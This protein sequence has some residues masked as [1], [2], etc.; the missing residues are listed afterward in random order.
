MSTM[1]VLSLLLLAISVCTGREHHHSLGALKPHSMSKTMKEPTHLEL[2]TQGSG[3]E[4]SGD[5][6]C[7]V[8]L[9]AATDKLKTCTAKQSRKM[10]PMPMKEPTHLELNIQNSKLKQEIE[11]LKTQGSGMERSGDQS[12]DVQLAAA[13]L[14]ECVCTTS[15]PPQ[16]KIV[17]L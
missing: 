8:Q 5:Q 9:T 1:R 3:M 17:Y 7:H 11:I 13:K 12:C 2:K 10:A 6:S 16:C 4:R 14:K 15:E